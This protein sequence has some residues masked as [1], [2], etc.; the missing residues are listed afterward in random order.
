CPNLTDV[1]F[2]GTQEDKNNITIN[3]YNDAIINAEWHFLI[4]YGD[5]DDDGFINAS[6]LVVLR[7]ALLK[8]SAVDEETQTKWNVNADDKIDILDLVRL[9]KYIAGMDVV[10]G[11]TE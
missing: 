6:D 1:Y 3:S 7:T 2:Y 9:K 10:L 8:L 5:A 11:P 4:R